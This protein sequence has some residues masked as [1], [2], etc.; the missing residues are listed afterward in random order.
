MKS[1]A[2]RKPYYLSG[3]P[4]P[5]VS[6]TNLGAEHKYDPDSGQVFSEVEIRFNSKRHVDW[7]KARRGPIVSNRKSRHDKGARSLAEM[8]II[9]VA[10]HIEDLTPDHLA[11][12]PW[13][14]AMRIWQQLVSSIDELFRRAESLYTWR[15]F[16]TAYPSS[17]EFG[18]PEYR[19]RVDLP[20][21]VLPYVEYFAGITS[22]DLSWLTC[23]RTSP[24]SKQMGTADLVAIHKITN[25]AVL[26]LS[27]G[28]ITIDNR[29]STFDER[30]MRSWAEL[31]VAGQAF[32]HLRVI[33]FGWQEF[34]SDWIFKYVHAFPSLCYIIVTDCPKMHQR[35]RRDWEP[36][37]VA[38]G[39]EAR[40]AKRSVKDLRPIIESA[41]PGLGYIS[42]FY[43]ESMELFK[44][45]THSG[46]PDL[47]ERLPLL[48]VEVGTPRLWRHI[49]DEFASTRT[50]FFENIAR[51]TRD[52]ERSMA[53]QASNREQTK[54]ARNQDMTPQGTA[55]P[56]PKRNTR[57]GHVPRPSGKSVSDLLGEF[58]TL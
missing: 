11:S 27:D 53:V 35:N 51:Q 4:R 43:D 54:R 23:L 31:A 46:R 36:L 45:L 22:N 1:K 28:P 3:R 14:M 40:R 7:V 32:R 42:G 52:E 58:Q 34:L 18:Q 41:K 25:L 9:T 6:A 48:E 19:F 49:V 16:A 21:P 13:P 29:S 44:D 38:M 2:T 47:V 55:S 5:V 24:N 10:R 20:T 37:S 39:W 50:I 56:P 30:V 17:E 33:L 12:V 26:D 15:T 57:T 8:A